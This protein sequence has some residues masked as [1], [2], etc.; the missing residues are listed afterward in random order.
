MSSLARALPVLG[1]LLTAP[2][3]ADPA[4]TTNPEGLAA[5]GLLDMCFNQHKVAEGFATYVGPTYRQHNPTAADGKEAAIKALSGFVATMPG[6]H[7]DFKRVLVDGD[8]VAV[9][10]H[11]TMGPSDRGMAV[12]DIFRFDNGKIV[13]HWDVAQPVPEKSANENTMF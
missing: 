6:M 12:V 2:A 3:F 11:V 4:L 9:H 7:Y 13:E 1:L 5:V 10:A 8:L